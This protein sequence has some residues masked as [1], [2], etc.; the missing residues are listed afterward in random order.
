[1]ATTLHHGAVKS[2]TELFDARFSAHVAAGNPNFA[3]TADDKAKLIAFLLSIDEG[4]APF[5]ILPETV[6]CPTGF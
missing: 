5:P 4:T 1:M 2:L 6:L 3:P